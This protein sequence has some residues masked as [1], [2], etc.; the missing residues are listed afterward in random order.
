MDAQAA[1]EQQKIDWRRIRETEFGPV[2]HLAMLNHATD[3]PLPARAAK[4]I[5]ERV[6]LLQ[7]PLAEVPPREECLEALQQRLG[8]FLNISPGQVGFFTNGADA[9]ATIVNGLSWS[10]GDEI[11]LVEGEFASFVYPWRT[12]ERLGVKLV[13]VPRTANDGLGVD[14][15]RIEAACTARTR[16]VAISHVE[17]QTG[18]R[19]DLA[20]IGRFA[21]AHG[22]A[23][24]VD[25]SQSLGA[26][27]LDMVPNG[28][29]A[30]V[31][32]AY[33]WLAGPHGISLLAMTESF[34]EQVYP[35]A[36]GRYAIRNGWQTSGFAL[37]WEPGLRRYQGGAYNWIGVC[38]LAESTRLIEDVGI[39]NYAESAFRGAGAL[40]AGLDAL[41]VRVVSTRDE[42]HRSQIVIW[43]LGSERADQRFAD[44]AAKAGV[45]LIQRTHGIR[46]GVHGWND[47]DDIDRLLADV[48]EQQRG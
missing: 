18:H 43:T 3:S 47:Q 17:Y 21:K 13:F 11:V 9:T 19:H 39:D 4:A 44:A 22:A 23:L 6:T 46:S 24:V 12:L 37:D 29:D 16:I 10:T 8:R 34:A 41:G 7:N 20:A 28:V 1:A 15:G 45:I 38:A 31:S 35:T 42:T 5:A 27:P 30:V 48:T 2:A 40:R 36:P 14:L 25:A 32:I 26:M 33:K